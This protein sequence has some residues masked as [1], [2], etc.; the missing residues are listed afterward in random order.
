M[1]GG[2]IWQD[3]NFLPKDGE[4]GQVLFK[5][6]DGE[7]WGDIKLLPD[8][9]NIGDYLVKSEDG[10]EFKPFDVSGLSKIDQSVSNGL[11]PISDGERTYVATPEQLNL[12]LQHQ[13]LPELSSISGSE[14]VAVV[15]NG[16]SYLASLTQIR[17]V[18]LPEYTFEDLDTN[19]FPHLEGFISTYSTFWQND[20]PY[21]FEIPVKKNNIVVIQLLKG[22]LMQAGFAFTTK[23]LNGLNHRDAIPFCHDSGIYKFNELNEIITIK[24]PED[25]E[26]LI[27]N[28]GFNKEFYSYSL[29]IG[30]LTE[31]KI[32]N[33]STRVNLLEQS[34]ISTMSEDSVSREEFD[35]LKQQL[36]ELK[37]KI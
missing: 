13:N 3:A 30:E 32:E 20:Y 6:D 22:N 27:V 24:V 19:K 12:M 25:A 16:I 8:D 2:E 5:T 23:S 35:S 10:V 17:Q 4:S 33:L 15:K 34:A 36:E 29:K 7:E 18:I 26:F 11:I 14:Q 9:G 31:D 28:S 1:G 21:R 37:S